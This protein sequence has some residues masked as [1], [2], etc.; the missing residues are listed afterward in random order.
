MPVNVAVEEPRARVIRLRKRHGKTS[1]PSSE[2][3]GTP[4][5]REANGDIVAAAANADNIAAHR[6]NIVGLRL[7]SALYNGEGM[8]QKALSMNVKLVWGVGC[9]HRAGGTDAG[10]RWRTQG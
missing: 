9:L 1:N 6:V 10:R 7:P 8:L 5:Y 3:E 4:A 2:S